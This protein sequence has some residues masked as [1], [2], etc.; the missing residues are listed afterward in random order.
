MFFFFLG[1]PEKARLQAEAKEAEEARR[2][3][4]AEAA[5]EAAIEAKRKLEL[6][7]EAAPKALLEV[8]KKLATN[9]GCYERRNEILIMIMGE[10]QTDGEVGRNKRELKVFQGL[11]TAENNNTNKGANENNKRGGGWVGCFGVWRQQSSRAAG[12]IYET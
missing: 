4:E 11:R 10:Q 9:V 7:R 12:A 8:K 5:A 3:A 2:K 6:E 1:V